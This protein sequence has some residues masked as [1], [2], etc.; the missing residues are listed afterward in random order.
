MFDF[1]YGSFRAV[2]WRT[3]K[4]LGL[5]DD[6]AETKEFQEKD[7]IAP[8]D[9]YP[10]CDMCGP[11]PTKD[12]M[13]VN[14]G[15]KI[16]ECS[17]CNCWFTSPR[18]S[19]EVWVNYLKTV[20]PRSIEFTENRLKYGVPFST[21]FKYIFP[22][23]RQRIAHH[24]KVILKEME[25]C[26]GRRI[27]RLHDAGCGVG[28]LLETAKNAGIEVT[29]NEL[30]KYACDKIKSR[31]N[32]P[33][34]NEALPDIDLSPN[35][36]DAVVMNDYIE[37][38]Y[39]PFQ[40]LKKAFTLQKPGGILYIRTFHINCKDFEEQKNNWNYLFWNHTHHFSPETLGNF[41]SKAGYTI[42]KS[43]SNYEA[44]AIKIL[45]KK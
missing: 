37:H 7:L 11:V 33:I 28:F 12:V 18:I 39:H 23:W 17:N 14:D 26:L 1:L 4:R 19:E 21:K 15:C 36:L 40:D 22:I 29:G 10:P 27:G 44:C 30:N 5:T 9:E 25:S 34:F 6:T 3:L 13:T 20:T 2:Y 42:I 35:S 41:I 43:E 31:L 16:V 8:F 32:V 38:S 24:D 45:A